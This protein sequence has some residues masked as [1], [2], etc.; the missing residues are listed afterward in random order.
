MKIPKAKQLPSGSWFAQV[1]ID[2]VRHSVT[3]QTEK[4]C[5]TEAMALKLRLK[6][7]KQD[8]GSITLREAYTQY[9]E[10]GDGVFSPS[11]V[12]GYKRLQRNTFQGI[13]DMKVRSITNQ[14]IQRDIGVMSREG[15]SPKYI[16]NAVGLLSPVLAMASPDFKLNINAPQK[17]KPDLR[18]LSDDEISQLVSAAAGDPVELPVMMALWMGM[19]LSEIRGAKYKDIFSKSG[20]PYLHICRAV[21]DDESGTGVEKGTKTYSGDRTIPIPEY[22]AKLMGTGDPDSYIVTLS[23]QAIY[24]RFSRL[25]DKAGIEHCRFHDLRRANAAAMIR[26]GVDSK[27]AMERNGWASDYMYKQVYGYV[28]QDKMDEV[29]AAM[30]FY[31]ANKITNEN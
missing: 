4:A 28:M 3:A 31:F 30:D 29:S 8:P 5:I 15:K 24:K 25:L 21:V 22:I 2:G 20:M 6:Q 26:L 1:M 13:M 27:Y 9:I 14:L 12:A 23:G 10:S 17:R 7:Q 19:R 18:M 16:A 11:T